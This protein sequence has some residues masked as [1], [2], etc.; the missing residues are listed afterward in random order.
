MR[1]VYTIIRIQLW[2]AYVDFLICHSLSH[3]IHFWILDWVYNFSTLN[4][5]QEMFFTCS[6]IF[7]KVELGFLLPLPSMVSELWFCIRIMIEGTRLDP[8]I[9]RACKKFQDPASWTERTIWEGDC[10]SEILGSRNAFTE[11]FKQSRVIFISGI[12]GE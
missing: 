12:R 10:R 9:L 8:N 7:L 1:W 2:N 3:A 5:P 6:S 11:E 4:F